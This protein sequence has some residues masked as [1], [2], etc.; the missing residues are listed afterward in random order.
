MYD[1]FDDKLSGRIRDVFENFEDDSADHGWEELRKRFPGEKKRKVA[2]LW[3]WRSAAIL[4]LTLGTWA[5]FNRS[6]EKIYLTGHKTPSETPALTQESISIPDTIS[7]AEF[8]STENQYAASTS[9]NVDFNK[10]TV[11]RNTYRTRSGTTSS[12]NARSYEENSNALNT[13]SAQDLEIVA[14]EEQRVVSSGTDSADVALKSIAKNET[15]SALEKLVVADMLTKRKEKTTA[16]TLTA[17]SKTEQSNQPEPRKT[18]KVT[19]GIS[20]GSYM[21]YAKGSEGNINTGVGILSDISLTKKLKLSTGVSIAQNT[22]KFETSIP[23][24]ATA[25]FIASTPKQDESADKGGFG[26]VN[27]AAPNPVSYSLSQYNASLLGLDI[28][29]NLKYSVL[30]KRN[31]LYFAA[32]LS[33]NFFLEEN[34]SYSYQVNS[35]GSSTTKQEDDNTGESKFKNFDLARM[36]NLSVGLEQRLTKQTRLSFEPFVKYPLGGQ[37]ARDIRFGSVGMNLKLN[38]NK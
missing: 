37:G 5:Y 14:K 16:A 19:I 6:T 32:G 12:A 31:E 9:P 28:P 4:F 11:A 1:Q 2:Y 13:T 23:Q 25:S 21:N 38:L 22:F 27:I 30:K 3:W 33:S 17:L 26:F 10:G 29:I 34:Y 8:N 20:A 18:S 15:V 36:L 7:S 35:A 24:A